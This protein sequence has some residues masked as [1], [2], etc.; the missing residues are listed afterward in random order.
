MNQLNQ[1]SLSFFCKGVK[2]RETEWFRWFN[3]K[4]DDR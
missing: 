4:E 3:N 2:K 1:L